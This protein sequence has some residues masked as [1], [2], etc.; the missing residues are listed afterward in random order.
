MLTD[1]QELTGGGTPFFSQGPSSR[2]ASAG[3]NSR[4]RNIFSILLFFN[5]YL[6]NKSDKTFFSNLALLSRVN[7]SGATDKGVAP[8]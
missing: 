7:P 8:I 3:T 2:S 5:Y 1:A 4:P 6:R